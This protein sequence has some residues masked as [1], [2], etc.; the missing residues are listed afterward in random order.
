VKPQNNFVSQRHHKFSFRLHFFSWIF[1]LAVPPPSLGKRWSLHLGPEVLVLL[2]ICAMALFFRVGYFVI[3]RIAEPVSGLVIR[4]ANRSPTF[5]RG[6]AA[7]ARAV[8]D[9]ETDRK[10]RWLT[11]EMTP[12][13]VH[14]F[15]EEQA[16]NRGAEILGEAAVWTV[17]LGLVLHQYVR[18]EEAAQIE[19]Q[20]R[21]AHE[22]ATRDAID[23]SERRI[24]DRIAALEQELA[25][26]SSDRR[27]RGLSWL[28]L[29]LPFGDQTLKAR[30]TQTG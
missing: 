2:W 19:Q 29:G 28:R 30:E 17:G 23:A 4:V 6:C 14:A 15:T 3:E 20:E 22:A 25:Q 12:A 9:A 5:Q 10:N 18:E 1:A 26:R 24:L 8:D 21:R 11:P 16:V 13:V 7:L 27:S